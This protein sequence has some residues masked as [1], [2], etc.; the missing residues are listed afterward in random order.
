MERL[1]AKKRMQTARVHWE[2]GE[3]KRERER[4]R[5]EENVP[6]RRLKPMGRQ[7]SAPLKAPRTTSR[8]MNNNL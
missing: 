6:E 4:E 2:E 3:R 8:C 7:K 1:Q 5:E